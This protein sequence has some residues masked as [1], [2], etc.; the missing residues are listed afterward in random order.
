MSSG[1]VCECE[2]SVEWQMGRFQQVIQNRTERRQCH[3]LGPAGGGTC[4]ESRLVECRWTAQWFE[5][6]LVKDRIVPIMGHDADDSEGSAMPAGEDIQAKLPSGV[7]GR[8][9]E[10]QSLPCASVT[11]H[12]VSPSH[13]LAHDLVAVKWFCR[14][15][16]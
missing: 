5:L 11:A 2:G 15:A 12:D 13:S 3:V 4:G 6:P 16:S 8:L 14:V 9:C 10:L 7:R 1:A